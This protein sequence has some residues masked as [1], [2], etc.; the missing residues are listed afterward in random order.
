MSGF[1]QAINDSGKGWKLPQVVA[2]LPLVETATKP[3]TNFDLRTE[4]DAAVGSI[5]NNP[6]PKSRQT[7]LA[8][9]QTRREDMREVVAAL[10]AMQKAVDQKMPEKDLSMMA[11]PGR[12]G[13]VMTELMETMGQVSKKLGLD[14]VPETPAG[15]AAAGS[16]GAD[17]TGGGASVRKSTVGGTR[18]QLYLALRLAT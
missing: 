14:V 16:E 9:V 11:G 13:T 1:I 12:L 4:L 5:L 2:M 8:K 15:D 10:E 18:D 6:N 3:Y 17:D 7:D